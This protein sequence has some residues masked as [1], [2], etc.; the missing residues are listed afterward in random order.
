MM[1]ENWGFEK[2][3]DKNSLP[4]ENLR[5]WKDVSGDPFLLS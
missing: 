4:T 1:D 2:M 5:N 3:P